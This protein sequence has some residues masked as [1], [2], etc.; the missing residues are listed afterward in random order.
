MGLFFKDKEEEKVEEKKS[1]TSTLPSSIKTSESGE[2]KNNFSAAA[3]T[4]GGVRKQEIVDYFKK[5]FAENNI[6]GPDYQEFTMALEDAKSDPMDEAT[7]IKTI[8][9][10]FKAMGLTPQRLV[11]T[12]NVYKKLFADK[13][14]AFDTA[15]QS[16]F[17]DQV[18]SKQKQ[19]DDLIQQNKSI[20]EEMRKLNDKK[21]A[22]E[23]SA[24][25][26]GDEIQAST[27]ELNTSK[28]DW[29]ITYEEVIKEIDDH[30]ALIN[31]HL[32]SI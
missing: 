1:T 6:P 3:T 24:K 22:N 14:A 13:L 2:F 11:E 26:I 4:T 27:S 31:K 28:N 23:K 32:I 8:Y 29:H 15:H 18:G 17:N 20:D 9:R 21:I 12:A 10:S 19:V 16:A 25:L 7:K 30:V 5:V